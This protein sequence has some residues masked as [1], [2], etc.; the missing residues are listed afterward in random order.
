[1]RKILTSGLVAAA[2]LLGCA[3]PAM[4]A[5][6]TAG[7]TATANTTAG[8][9]SA[10]IAFLRALA[11][12]YPAKSPV[13]LVAADVQRLSATR[14]QA[15]PSTT[16]ITAGTTDFTAG[17][18][19]SCASPTA[20]LSVG[21]HAV[22]RG[23][24]DTV[25]PF[26]ARLHA[27][28]W[29][30][31]PVKTPKGSLFTGLTDV[32]CKAATYC[33]VVGDAAT[34]SGVGV[35]PYT[36]TWNGT[37][38]TPTAAPPLPAR[39]F[40]LVTSVSCV[41]VKSCLAA[42]FGINETTGVTSTIMWTWDGTRWARTTVPG[43]DPSTLTEYTRLHCFS[44]RSCA[45]TGD[46]M[47]MSAAGTG[48]DTPV[49]ALWNG[50]VFTG[51]GAPLPAGV[52]DPV[53]ND[54]SCVSA[55]SCAVVGAGGTG[56]TGTASVGFAE[57]WNGKSWTVT[58]WGGPKG[59]TRAELLGVSCTRAVRCIAVGD[60]GTA[61][62]GTPAALAWNGSKW[63][64]LK[65]AGPGAGKAAAF[66]AISC[67]VNGQC[68]TTGAIGKADGSTGSP[69]AGYWNGRTWTYGPM[70]RPAAA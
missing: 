31:V 27:G 29:K 41:A 68:V 36:L 32:S 47:D 13:G 49:A 57:V 52:S 1:M 14:P 3:G 17:T 64:V 43:A 22:S 11:A 28:T 23:S 9:R 46:A 2:A 18:S 38:L 62:A 19:V 33:L 7:T 60:H 35:A 16:G 70:L 44:V 34:Q 55:G 63:M 21:I 37:T 39:T 12:R 61:K 69:V 10:E 51:M 6:G 8:G 66:A 59:D 25:T 53:F 4:A 48:T 58:K 15:S 42:G 67:P 45:L 20:C 65:V 30:A 24:S 5:T 54:L 56:R 26:A 40:G 50:T